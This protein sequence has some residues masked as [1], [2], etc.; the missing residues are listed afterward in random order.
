MLKKCKVEFHGNFILG[1]VSPLEYKQLVKQL[2]SSR[3]NRVYE[4][5]KFKAPERV[6]FT[7]Q[8]VTFDKMASKNKRILFVNEDT[9]I[10]TQ[11]RLSHRRDVIV[12]SH[13]ND[14]S[15]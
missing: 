9:A 5:F 8:K 7:K 2:G 1:V 4:F 12:R 13:T 6:G 15:T 11:D 3:K 14:G 10:S